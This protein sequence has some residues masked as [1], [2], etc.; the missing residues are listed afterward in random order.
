MK[1]GPFTRDWEGLTAVVVGNGPSLLTPA[2]APTLAALAGNHGAG[3]K[4][5]VANGGYKLLPGADVLMCSDRHWLKANP[6]LSGYRG[7]EIV[8]TRP[9]AVMVEDSRMRATGHEFIERVRGDIFTDPNRLVEGH[10]STST[11]ISLAVLRGV[12][13]ILLL[14]V[15]L[16]PGKDLRRRTYDE[17]Q[18][19]YISAMVR[20]A[21]QVRHLGLQAYWVK[22]RQIEVLNC[23]PKSDL[24]CYPY[25]SFRE[26]F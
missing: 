5:L 19:D 12:R 25:A 14:G 7:P 13:R 11:N 2:Y 20:Y 4:V 22:R 3:A 16:A 24:T 21:K 10:N 6:D 23:S 8:V 9:E 17:S 1:R 26:V 15:D 18:D